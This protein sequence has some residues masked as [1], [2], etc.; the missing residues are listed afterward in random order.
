LF[1]R[2]VLLPLPRLQ[3][4]VSNTVRRVIYS[5]GCIFFMMQ[6]LIFQKKSRQKWQDYLCF[7]FNSTIETILY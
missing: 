1:M 2:T 6:D 5:K 7:N 4:T 3:A